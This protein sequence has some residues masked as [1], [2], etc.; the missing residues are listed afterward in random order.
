MHFGA[1]CESKC[2]SLEEQGVKEKN[3]MKEDISDVETGYRTKS[4]RKCGLLES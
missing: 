1:S 2:I 4:V 3:S